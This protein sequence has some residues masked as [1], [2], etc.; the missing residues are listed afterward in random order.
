MARINRYDDMLM[1]S[2]GVPKLLLTF[3]PGPGTMMGAELIAWCAADVAGIDI[4]EHDLVAGHHTP[5]DQPDA[6]ATTIAAWLN[7]HAFASA[8]AF[9]DADRHTE[10]VARN[11]GIRPSASAAG[12]TIS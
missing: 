7:K 11:L 12:L 4:A 10:Q 3:Q 1:T 9:G 6:I 8:S 5:E 2:A